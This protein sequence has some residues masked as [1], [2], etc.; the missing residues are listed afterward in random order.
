M[1]TPV[2]RLLGVAAFAL[3]LVAF[4]ILDVWL[5][6][7]GPALEPLDAR[8]DEGSG[9]PIPSTDLPVLGP[10]PGDPADLPRT[11]S[12]G[13]AEVVQ[14]SI[15]E[16]A[17]AP[18]AITVHAIRRG[19]ATAI[20]RTRPHGLARPRHVYYADVTLT[21]EGLGVVDVTPF[22]T[23]AQGSRELNI[24]HAPLP[25]YR[26]FPPC[27]GAADGVTLRA[28]EPVDVCM[29]FPGPR[30]ERVRGVS[31]LGEAGVPTWEGP[32]S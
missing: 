28:G 26:P 6:G 32:V 11:L 3:V 17:W 4:V 27:P 14:M 31:I 7:D 20:D 22:L 10:L 30:P 1:R 13:A 24:H 29:V 21:F 2:G 23:L 15:G 25:L 19:D 12:F 8:G 16:D 18:V 5:G 9:L